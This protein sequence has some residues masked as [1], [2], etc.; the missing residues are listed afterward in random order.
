[1]GQQVR[2]YMSKVDEREFVAFLRST[3]DVVILPQTSEREL[4]EYQLF[5]DLE[6]RKLG[7]ACHLWNRS[8]SARPVVE[9]YAAHGGCYCVDFMKSEVVNVMPSKMRDGHLSMGR[10]H[11]EDKVLDSNGRMGSKSEAFLNW[12]R[13]V[14]DWI[15]QRYKKGAD[16]AYVA[17]GVE[18]LI[19]KGARLTG[20][21]L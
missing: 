7:E 9:Y 14:C 21:V 4:E 2:F 20:H 1:M 12:F 3:G 8:I 6:G 16:G 19:R 15:K 18:A 17:P 10:L 5:S 13:D 11:I